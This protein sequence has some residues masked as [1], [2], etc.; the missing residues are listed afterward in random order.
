MFKCYLICV[1]VVIEYNVDVHF[2]ETKF[3]L[4]NT[5][6]TVKIQLQT[7][8]SKLTYVTLSKKI[9]TINLL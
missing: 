1:F 9:G 2:I 8:Y 6:E 7:Q 3:K 5:H 4:K